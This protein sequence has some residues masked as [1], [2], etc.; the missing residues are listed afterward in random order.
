ME[1]KKENY[2]GTEKISK[3]LMTFAIPSIIG[4]IV[5]SLYN[6]VDQIFIGWGV[7]Y[8][9][10]GATTIIFPI[11]MICLAFALMFGD[12]ASA[13]LSLKLG[14]NKKEEAKKGVSSTILTSM[15]FSIII[16]AFIVGFLPLLVN[17][18]GCTDDI[19]PYALQ[20]GLF[21]GIGFPFM[22]IGTTI[23]SLIRADGSPE[24][25]MIS[26]MIGAIVNCILDP[27]F[28]FVFKMG[29]TGAA[30]ATLIAQVVSF[31]I[32]INYLRKFKTI[33]L[34][35][36]PKHISLKYVLKV[37][38]LGISSFITQMSIVAV[39]TTEN[40]VLSKVGEA[41]EFGP[42]IP[43]TVLGIVMK[44]NQILNSIII[45][46][47]VGS[48]PIVGFNYGARKYDRVKKTLK[49]V[50]SISVAISTIALVLFQ[51]I[52]DKLIVIFGK[53]DELY[54]KFAVMAFR[55]YLMMTILNG[56]QIPSS[57]F[58]QAIGKSKKSI[59]VS[60]SRQVIVLIPSMILFAKYFGINGVL[61]SGPFADTVAFIITLI[62]LFFEI[63][64]MNKKIKSVENNEE[65][66]PTKL[67]KHVVITI[68]REYGSGGRFVG[69][70]VAKELGINCYDKNFIQKL[71]SE[72]EM[73]QNYIE[74]K[75]QKETDISNN[76]LLTNADDLF[77]EESKLVKKLYDE[78]SCV[79]IGRCADYILKDKKDVLKVFISASEEEKVNRAVKY[80]GVDKKKAK[81]EID[82][83]NKLRAKHYKHYT[84]REWN[85]PEN[86]DLMLKVD[87]FGVEKCAKIIV[88]NIKNK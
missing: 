45:G 7:G 49:F 75:E 32:N 74:E 39:M 47:A 60:L 44:I 23:N 46:L 48:Q 59:F 16:T 51:T 37:C 76:G 11:N 70:L 54:T 83:I 10:N 9:G 29:V 73:S 50:I 17:L 77:I 30:V 24:Y 41:S 68:A 34:D 3:L 18:F 85:N 62:L 38:N 22:M 12:G 71:A 2:L 15:I 5:N 81:S 6:I 40:N 1:N 14:E 82:K 27:I 35:F 42:N 86:Y 21:I 57:I 31:A 25:S 88:E 66:V 87:D 20:Y 33:K 63:K 65:I 84:D 52:P 4:M 55:T 78:E 26:M 79:I 19:R 69:K 61:Y 53:G 72:T 43:L 67:D 8:L 64:G 58:F 28:I 80:Y 56:V 36:N 13:F